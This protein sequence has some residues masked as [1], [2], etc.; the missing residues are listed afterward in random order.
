LTPSELKSPIQDIL[1]DTGT[2]PVNVINNDLLGARLGEEAMR[3]AIH[4]NG[5]TAETVNSYFETARPIIVDNLLSTQPPILADTQSVINAG[6]SKVI[7]N[8]TKTDGSNVKFELLT[9]K[10]TIDYSRTFV[11]VAVSGGAVSVYNI[12]SA[13]AI[14]IGCVR[15]QDS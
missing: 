5:T 11:G 1:E 15:R 4:E 12:T 9:G 7:S 10:L 2:G 13:L 3:V 8:E 14:V 6:I